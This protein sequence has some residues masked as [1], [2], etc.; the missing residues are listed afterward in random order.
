MNQTVA[1][2]HLASWATL[3]V[4]ANSGQEAIELVKQHTFDLVL[5]DIQMPEMDGIVATKGIRQQEK[6][7]QGHI[8]IIAMTAHAMKGDRDRCLDA[9]MDGYVSKPISPEEVEAAIF[10]VILSARKRQQRYQPR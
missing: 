5:M 6:S 4:M 7:S 3:S 10:A 2:R 1:S 9:G 8:P